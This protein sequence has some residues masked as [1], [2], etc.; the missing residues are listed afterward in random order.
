MADLNKMYAI[1]IDPHTHI[2]TRAYLELGTRLHQILGRFPKVDEYLEFFEDGLIKKL[3]TSILSADSTRYK[4]NSNELGWW[5]NQGEDIKTYLDDKKIFCQSSS[6]IGSDEN[7]A[8]VIRA[9]EKDRI[10]VYRGSI[11]GE[12]IPII[13]KEV[14]EKQEEISLIYTSNAEIKNKSPMATFRKLP[15]SDNT[16]IVF[17]DEPHWLKAA[18][19]PEDYLNSKRSWSYF[20][21][22]PSDYNHWPELSRSSDQFETIGNGCYSMHPRGRKE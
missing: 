9:Y 13:G 5:Q 10:K 1:D 4:F 12:I 2:F 14:A 20:V 22:S 6:W 16:R 15:I 7:L 19:V 18:A 17:T 3:A 8:K 21:F 11:V